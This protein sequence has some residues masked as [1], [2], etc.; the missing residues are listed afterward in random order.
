MNITQ[1]Q[2]KLPFNSLNSLIVEWGKDKGILSKATP[3]TQ[4][5]K[6][7]EEV[8]ELFEALMAQ[9][10]YLIEYSN[11]KGKVVNTE[12]EIK[13]A[14]GDIAVTLLLQC[15][16]QNINFLDA[17]ESAYNVIKGRQGKM[18]KGVFVKD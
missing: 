3:L 7:K 16:L 13:D 11:S 12:E 18:V 15:A 6:T 10:N 1:E 17:I 14:I 2:Y 4:L 9:N 8:D 5:I